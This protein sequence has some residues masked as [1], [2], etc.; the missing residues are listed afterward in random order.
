MKKSWVEKRDCKKSYK[1]KTIDKKFADMPQESEML[2]VS[3]PFNDEYIKS[4]PIRK[5]IEPSRIRDALARKYKADNTCPVTT[6]IFL[7]IISEAPY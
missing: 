6:G 1:I 2:I 7:R 3:L 4:I 5:S